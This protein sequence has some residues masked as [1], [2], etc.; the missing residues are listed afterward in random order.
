MKVKPKLICISLILLLSMAIFLGCGSTNTATQ[1]SNVS[2]SK[3]IGISGS[4]DQKDAA[5]NTNSSA[6]LSKQTSAVINSKRKI[7]KSANISLNTK[8]IDKTVTSITN[9]ISKLGGYI[10]S[11]DI[12]GNKDTDNRTG[13]LIVKIPK[14]NFDDFIKSVGGYGEITSKSISGKDVTD[15]YFD[16]EAHLKS[17]QVEESRLLDLLKGSG[18]LKTILDIEKELTNVRYQIETLT[19]T[20]K[21]YDSLVDYSQVTISINEVKSFENKSPS[22]LNSIATTFKASISV[23]VSIC[24]ALLLALIA[25]LPFAPIIIVIVVLWIFFGK[26]KN[27]KK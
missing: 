19:G 13:N 11:S 24:K 5:A 15:E 7:I 3:S 21:K 10:E 12:Q 22:L 27:P 23:L 18:D 16:S 25:I 9:E 8:N 2:N 17:L 20:L 26:R 1:S 4:A 6:T 14:D